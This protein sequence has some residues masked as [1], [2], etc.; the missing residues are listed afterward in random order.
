[1]Q[2][3]DIA[4]MPNE[5]VETILLDETILI[6]KAAPFRPGPMDSPSRVGIHFIALI[7]NNM[8]PSVMVSPA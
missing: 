4:V 8:M 6:T 1:M 2:S 5:V 3:K 7:S